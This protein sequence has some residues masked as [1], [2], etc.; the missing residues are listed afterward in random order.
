MGLAVVGHGPVPWAPGP[1][2][3]SC[4]SQ[5]GCWWGPVAEARVQRVNGSVC[6]EAS[7]GDTPPVQHNSGHLQS[8]ETFLA[9]WVSRCVVD[10]SPMSAPHPLGKLRAWCLGWAP[11]QESGLLGSHHGLPS[12]LGA[13]VAASPSEAPFSPLLCDSVS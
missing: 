10:F 6:Q 3:D 5:W 11:C 13:T 8:S 9:R 12:T 1:P 7:A 4:L 2:V